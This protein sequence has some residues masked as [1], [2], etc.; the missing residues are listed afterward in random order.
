MDHPAGLPPLLGSFERHLRA[1]NRADT[2]VATPEQ[3]MR[4]GWLSHP[5]Q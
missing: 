2:T 5:L 1:T 4:P 3:A